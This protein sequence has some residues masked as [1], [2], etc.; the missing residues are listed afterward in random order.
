MN[1]EL[2][3]IQTTNWQ[4]LHIHSCRTTVFGGRGGFECADQNAHRPQQQRD[5]VESIKALARLSVSLG[6]I[7]IVFDMVEPWTDVERVFCPCVHC[8]RHSS[9]SLSPLN[10]RRRLSWSG[11]ALWHTLTMPPPANGVASNTS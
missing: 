9:N 11:A 4:K 3:A 8:C 2:C 5:T 10:A 6:K 7:K 1:L